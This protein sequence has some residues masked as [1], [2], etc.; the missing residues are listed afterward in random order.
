MRK[1]LFSMRWWLA[2][3]FAA[4]VASTALF[5][6]EVMTNR[7][8]A[9]FRSRAQDL[10]AGTT[11]DAA[12][13]LKQDNGHGSLSE[14]TA[15]I[16][17][18]KGIALFVFDATGK[19]LTSK[20]SRG[21]EI[22]SIEAG[23]DVLTLPLEGKRVV[24]TTDDGR[25]I[26]VGLPLRDVPP[27]VALVGVASRPD[28]VA[29]GRIV[30]GKVIGAVALAVSFGALIGIVVAFFI[31]SRLRRIAQT[32]SAIG[33]GDF[34]R[35]LSSRFPDELGQ[36]AAAIDTMRLRLSDSFENLEGERSRLARLLEQL[37]EGV[38]AVDS[39]LRI[40][41]A[42][43]RARLLLH[44]G[45]LGK[46]D[47]LPDPWPGLSLPQLAS[48]L[49]EPGVSVIY[50]RVSPVPEKT[51]AVAGVPARAGVALLVITDV[52]LQ[53]RRERAEREFVTNAAHELRTPLSAIAGA[54]EA[55]ESGAKDEPEGR[56]RFIAI[57]SRQTARL[58]RLVQALLALARAQTGTEQL[59]LEPVELR[60]LLR[61]IAAEAN[62]A[63]THVEL[64]CPEDLR[65]I[66][67][68]D[69][70]RQAIENLVANAVKYGGREIEINAEE[71]SA[72]SSRISIVDHGEGLSPE[73]RDRAFDRFFRAGGRSGDGFGLGLPIAREIVS[74]LTGEIEID[75]NPGGG[76]RVSIV[77]PGATRI[78]E[79]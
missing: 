14:A 23:N 65:A 37:Q 3:V 28:L 12:N 39:G 53:E 69:L 78:S 17:R 62:S 42:N 44:G 9:A 46:G 51:Y 8:E 2:L 47:A 40:V 35:Q 70:L 34:E 29:A 48:Q 13:R 63:G 45:P 71:L 55:L 58:G 74:A 25:R 61:E 11:V 24:Q 10:A 49:F 43:D 75:S 22:S 50:Q 57:V 15:R 6:A 54:A 32:A 19:L 52:S 31:T 41:Y 18:E 1:G 33:A 16:A 38:L 20:R 30:H 27:A 59:E 76:T 56:D 60:P 21:I 26:L 68:S 64:D 5:V 77:L 36:L 73:Q 7:S 66:T 72:Q 79:R 4:I 67:H